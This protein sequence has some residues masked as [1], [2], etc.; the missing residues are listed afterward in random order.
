MYIKA[1]CVFVFGTIINAQ[2]NGYLVNEGYISE[3]FGYVLIVP[4]SLLVGYATFRVYLKE[5]TDG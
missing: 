3:L 5:I 2:T 1:G 4:V